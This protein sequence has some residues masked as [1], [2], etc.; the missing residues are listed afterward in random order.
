MNGMALLGLF[1]VL[2]GIAVGVIAFKKPKA[3]WEMRKIQAFLNKLGEKGTVIFFYIW[4]I[5]A[6][7]IGIWL[8]VK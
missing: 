6:F 7:G 2:Y 4:G 5:V 3:V 1:L 8:L